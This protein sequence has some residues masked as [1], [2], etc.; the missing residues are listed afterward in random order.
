MPRTDVAPSSQPARAAPGP[1][2]VAELTPTAGP[3]RL[4]RLVPLAFSAALAALSLLPVVRGH[5]ALA[6]TLLW[7]AGALGAWHA[8]LVWRRPDVRAGVVLR[9]QHYVQACAQG[10]ILLY[11]GWYWREVY[12]AAHLLLAQLL[13]AYAFDLLLSWSRRGTYT[14]GFAPVPV[15]FSINLFLWFRPDWFYFQFLL[16]AV[17][18]AAKELVRWNKDGRHVHIFNPSSFPL[19]LFSLGLILTGTTSLTWGQEIATTLNRAPQIYLAIFLVSL[20][21]Q[22]LFGVATMTVAA[23]ATTYL[24]GLVYFASAGTYYFIDAYIPI[25]VFLGMHLLFTD[26]STAPRTELGRLLF[27]VAYGLSVIVLYGVLGALGQP[28]FYDKLLAVPLLNLMIQVIDRLSRTVLRRIDPAAWW[29]G[30]A[31]TRRNAAWVGVWTVVFVALS[32]AQGVGDTHRGA[33]V[34]FWRQACAADLPNGCRHF[35]VLVSAFC[36]NG[37]GWACNEYGL[38]LQPALRPAPA[39]DAFRRACDLGS[40]AGCTNLDRAGTAAVAR[41]PP[42]LADYEIV[43]RAGRRPLPAGLPPLAIYRRACAQGFADGCRQACEGGDDAACEAV[44]RNGPGG[45][46]P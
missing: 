10:T 26:P 34:T 5:A 4:V 15:I 39:A 43:V 9:R 45:A 27:G 40:A 38:L 17:G 24:F 19:G 18:F 46:A 29:R 41:E 13:F 12:D 44:A 23:V 35:G 14:I 30:L 32:A 21:V 7:A 31:G 20:P 25:A 28:R 8:L 16:I 11:W 3:S 36:N 1:L 6:A 37:S 42:T 22:L 2:R 33:Q